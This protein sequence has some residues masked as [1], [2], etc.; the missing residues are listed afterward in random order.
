MTQG[1]LFM[2]FSFIPLSAPNSLFLQLLSAYYATVMFLGMFIFSSSLFAAIV[3]LL[4]TP[5]YFILW[6]IQVSMKFLYITRI[7]ISTETFL[8]FELNCKIATRSL[9]KQNVMRT[10]SRKRMFQQFFP[11]SL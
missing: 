11:C 2:S 4:E 1:C 9:G 5:S 6:N 3:L 10:R 8:W 7:C